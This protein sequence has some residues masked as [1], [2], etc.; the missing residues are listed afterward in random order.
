[1]KKLILVEA[2]IDTTERGEEELAR[3]ITMDYDDVTIAHVVES[4][5]ALSP[6]TR[7][8]ALAA[9]KI[10]EDLSDGDGHIATVEEW[11]IEELGEGFLE[12][13]RNAVEEM[14]GNAGGEDDESFLVVLD[15]MIEATEE[16]IADDGLRADDERIHDLSALL[17]TREVYEAHHGDG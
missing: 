15:G 6:A 3:A 10:V 12:K 5:P 17:R 2:D 8:A 14:A 11:A 9:L 7:Q 1:M 13:L 16:F 4:P